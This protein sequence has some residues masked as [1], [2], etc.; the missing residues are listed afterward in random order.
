MRHS[1]HIRTAWSQSSPRAQIP[2]ETEVIQLERL[3]PT[4]SEDWFALQEHSA[5]VQFLQVQFSSICK[6]ELTLR[7]ACDS[8]GRFEPRAAFEAVFVVR[9][10]ERVHNEI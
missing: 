10:S 5:I 2:A 3:K 4:V 6:F 7:S 1:R 9:M 8:F